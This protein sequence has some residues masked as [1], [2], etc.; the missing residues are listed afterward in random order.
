MAHSEM[1]QAPAEK[2]AMGNQCQNTI[3]SLCFATVGMKMKN[4]VKVDDLA[5]EFSGTLPQ[6]VGMTSS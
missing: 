6:I 4:G 5:K 2:K 1:E 3:V